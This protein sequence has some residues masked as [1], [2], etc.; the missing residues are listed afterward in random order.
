MSLDP[1]E[2]RLASSVLNS[3]IDVLDID[4]LADI[5]FPDRQPPG[6]SFI[7]GKPGF[8]EAH[9]DGNS[10]C[11]PFDELLNLTGEIKWDP[12]KAHSFLGWSLE[13]IVH[14]AFHAAQAKQEGVSD[15]F[16]LNLAPLKYF[17][18]TLVMEADA[19]ARTIWAAEVLKRKNRSVITDRWDSLK[20]GDLT[21]W[22]A[23]AYP[24]YGQIVNGNPASHD[25]GEAQNLVAL[26]LLNHKPFVLEQLTMYAT[27]LT[28]TLERAKQDAT[29]SESIRLN[30]FGEK[31]LCWLSGIDKPL[32]DLVALGDFGSRNVFTNP[33][34]GSAGWIMEDDFLARS[35]TR[36]ELE[37]LLA[38]IQQAS[39]E[40]CGILGLA[41]VRGLQA[42]LNIPF[43]KGDDGIR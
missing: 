32:P 43:P 6:F 42:Q 22:S 17:H 16:T 25:T 9:F 3:I 27:S 10:I 39:D 29:E 11:M 41:P 14:E 21:T 28:Q 8:V 38:P 4:P 13:R 33:K 35:V 7:K 40:L 23:Q 30:N 20:N 19:Y 5:I 2:T 15:I 31:A 24:I 1:R 34:T 12:A 37:K 36:P 26:S 18:T